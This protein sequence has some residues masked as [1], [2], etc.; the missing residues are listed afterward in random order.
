MELNGHIAGATKTNNSCHSAC[1][2][3]ALIIDSKVVVVG[4]FSRNIA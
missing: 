1:N 3:Y 4:T 2:V